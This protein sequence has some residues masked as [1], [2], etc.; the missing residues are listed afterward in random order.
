MDSMNDVIT[1]IRDGESHLTEK[2]IEDNKD[3]IL[4][5]VSVSL[6]KSTVVKN[7]DE[8]N[9]GLQAF[10]Y[11]IDSYEINSDES[12]LEFAEKNIKKW[13]MDYLIKNSQSYSQY[14]QS[15][16]EGCYDTNCEA[17]EEISSLKEEL[18]KFGITILDLVDSTPKKPYL[19][20]RAVKL[21]KD[22]SNSNELYK[23]L[24]NTGR[25]Q[26]GNLEL[27]STDKK[28]LSEYSKFVIALC[29]IMKSKLEI[30]KGYIK[31]VEMQ[32]KLSNSLGVVLEMKGI[33]AVIITEDCRFALIDRP[34]NTWVGSEL[35]YKNYLNEKTNVIRN[36]YLI[37]AACIFVAAAAII[38]GIATKNLRTNYRGNMVS[39]EDHTKVNN[40]AQKDGDA[41]S[42]GKNISENNLDGRP[43]DGSNDL[44]SDLPTPSELG[45]T[46]LSSDQKNMNLN[47]PSDQ[48]QM[49]QSAPTLNNADKNKT[50]VNTTINLSTPKAVPAA[51]VTSNPNVKS[52]D[53]QTSDV[54]AT[55][56]PEKDIDGQQEKLNE[57]KATGEPGNVVISS[58]RNNVKVNDEFTIKAL[59]IGG[60]NGTDWT[61]YE[62]GRIV[63][64]M[65]RP[66]NTPDMQLITRIITAE[67]PGLYTYKCV[68]SNSFGS[69]ESETIQVV[70]TQ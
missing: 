34:L 26:Y 7:S 51:G 18:W 20:M 39:M 9:I 2:F 54:S 45:I 4:R 13:I 5:V 25:I 64:T 1:R 66:D 29:L 6:D 70:V 10:K 19:V 35:Q 28:I 68:F 41:K 23:K 40:N 14:N 3:F 53:S 11:S 52:P 47:N 24:I 67:M 38:L 17:S 12:F 27:D 63:S 21:A 33:S 36:K 8:F 69:S 43:K 37:I 61:L 55:N 50:S 60:N 44:K 59:M 42:D 57:P 48:K 16:S 58:D 62:N 65:K 31:N 46:Q 32:W 15:F 49:P 22:I 30:I 56:S